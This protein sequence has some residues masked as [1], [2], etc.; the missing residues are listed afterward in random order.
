M[1]NLRTAEHRIRETQLQPFGY[2][3]YNAQEKVSDF[4]GRSEEI[5]QF[6]QYIRLVYQKGVSQAVRLEG[7]LGAG[8]STLFNFI[9]E[10][11]EKERIDQSRPLTF[12]HK[13]VDVLSTY[14][15]MPEGISGFRSIWQKV[16]E[17]M[18]LEEETGELG[19]GLAE[20]VGLK[21]ISKLLELDPKIVSDILWKD[22]NPPDLRYINFHEIV[23][24]VLEHANQVIPDLQAYYNKH[25][26]IIRRS[27][28]V[29][30]AGRNF[31]LTRKD[32]PKIINLLR[33]LNEDDE[34]NYYEL[35]NTAD[36]SLFPT[37]DSVIEFFNDLRR[38]YICS[39]GK[40]LILLLGVD[41]IVKYDH[42]IGESFYGNLGRMFSKWRDKLHS[43]LFVFISTSED[44]LL[45]DNN[46]IKISDLSQQ[47]QVLLQKMTLTQLSIE[48]SVLVFRERMDR[49]WE[50]Y[51]SE[52][53]SS[54]PYFP[55]TSDLFEY[56]LRFN[57]RNLRSSII[58]LNKLW[59]EFR[60]AAH[61]PIIDNKLK[62]LKFVRNYISNGIYCKEFQKFDWNIVRRYYLDAAIY[63]SNSKRSSDIEKGLE[64]AW[65][66]LLRHE[67]TMITR[68]ENNPIIKFGT[69]ERRPDIIVEI[70]GQMGEEE[71]R[72][73]EFQVKAYKPGNTISYQ[74]IKSS[75]ELFQAG[76][77]DLLYFIMSGELDNQGLNHL[78]KLATKFPTR[79]RRPPLRDYQIN[80]QFFL[81]AYN[82]IVG[83]DLG[84]NPEID[85]ENARYSIE[86]I[87]DQ[88]IDELFDIVRRMPY[89]PLDDNLVIAYELDVDQLSDFYIED[90]VF[91]GS[92]GEQKN[93]KELS[94][95][96]KG[97]S[98]IFHDPTDE[99]IILDEEII[100]ESDEVPFLW[101][102]DFQFLRDFIH[103]AVA[104]VQY[105]MTREDNK[106]YR[107]KYTMATFRKNVI[108]NNVMLEFK[109]FS[110]FNDILLENNL[111][112]KIKSSF[113]LTQNGLLWYET[114]K[115]E[116]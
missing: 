12:L 70:L 6:K 108:D 28:K 94:V 17:G 100:N 102:N 15:R 34:D 56:I 33:I 72:R 112:N 36:K 59:M 1:L 51:T 53:P 91:T 61:I 101:V 65:K 89:R 83:W 93:E 110:T 47:I 81:A 82:A 8:K 86:K 69:H 21:F 73:I 16:H 38:Y 104:L 68:V 55:F 90:E 43:V 116:L 76:Y 78:N 87:I 40:G 63:K 97:I 62:A 37:D 85:L 88:S 77:T 74:H 98:G 105:L 54:L 27:L 66:C 4:V 57:Q 64:S 2:S 109:R 92:D 60:R 96:D 107:N 32:T 46:I 106:R 5:S 19:V 67:N 45:F 99:K 30:H 31:E 80:Y 103:E 23:Q 48:D 35:I 44:W 9:K 20:Y 79:I 25:K 39:T 49:F 10:E 13:D 42:A 41:E 18:S 71:K 11:I 26:K 58:M 75:L 3:S 95:E 115:N 7:P 29:K 24:Q 113:T 84:E 111:I 52:R 14:F 114:V 50:N 22:Q